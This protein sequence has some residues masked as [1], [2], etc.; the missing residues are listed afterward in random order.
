MPT[1][2]QRD[3]KVTP[4]FAFMCASQ[5][6]VCLQSQP[7]S[8]LASQQGFQNP[9]APGGKSSQTQLGESDDMVQLPSVQ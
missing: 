8:V 6:L 7:E 5:S 3:F 4:G 9:D 1:P 2:G